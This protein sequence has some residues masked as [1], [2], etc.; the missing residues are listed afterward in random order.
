[1][2]KI[3]IDSSGRKEKVIKLIEDGRVVCEKR[4]ELD[5]VSTIAQLLRENN[6][7]IS[8]INEFE[9]NYGPG[10][11]TGLK[12]GV[13]VCNILNWALGKKDVKSLKMPNYGN[14]PNITQP[15][16]FKLD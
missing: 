8:D 6:L 7:K 9:P 16:K 1:M 4:G 10:S 5:I 2:N 3:Y 11:Y 12:M 15:K 14:E 13:T